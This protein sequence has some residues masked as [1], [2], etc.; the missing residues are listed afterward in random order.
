MMTPPR[1]ALPVVAANAL[2]EIRRKVIM[3]RA[4]REPDFCDVKAAYEGQQASS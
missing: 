3:A 1:R 4:Q 2:G